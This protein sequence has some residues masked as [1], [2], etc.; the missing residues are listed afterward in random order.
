MNV[1][2]FISRRLKLKPQDGSRVSSNG[3]I[4]IAGIALSMAVMILSVTVVLGFKSQIRAKV[5][6][7]EASITVSGQDRYDEF[8]RYISPHV[9]VDDARL[10]KELVGD[11]PVSL[12]MSQSGVIK[13]HSDFAGLEFRG[14]GR[15]HDWS[16][17][18]E[19]LS[20]GSVDNLYN[21]D[22][23]IIISKV[24]ANTLNLSVNDKVDAYFFVNDNLKARRFSVAGVYDTNFGEHDRSVCYVSLKAVQSICDTDSTVGDH[25]EV[26]SIPME[27]I[28]DITESLNRALFVDYVNR[29]SSTG[30]SVRL[31]A[32]NVLN[33]GAAYFN[34]LDLLDMNVIVILCLMTIVSGFTLISS[35]F[36]L[37]LERVKFVG[38]LKSMGATNGQIRNVFI[39]LAERVIIKGMIIGN[40]VGIGIAYLQWKFQ[41]I[42][43]NPSAYY[44]SSV[45]IEFSWMALVALNAGTILLSTA[46]LLIPARVI[47]GIAP[48]TTMKYE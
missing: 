15:N 40:I 17:I 2:Y 21:D 44:L 5:L 11:Y 4:G 34:W 9:D 1:S 39:Y 43:L 7:L 22:K 48:S 47:A 26:A 30:P 41:W 18:R 3:A 37:I 27:Q 38:I 28:A 23:S 19:S 14:Y 16:F 46:I 45:P 29:S 12:A 35:L 24:T 10:I 42:P 8:G 36:I 6:G 32:D 31:T 25:I 20:E 13:T 33:S